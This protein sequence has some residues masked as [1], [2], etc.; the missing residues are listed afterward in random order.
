MKMKKFGLY[1]I[2]L[3]LLVTN[4]VDSGLSGAQEDLSP[5]IDKL[6]SLEKDI[7]D[8]QRKIN[9]TTINTDSNQNITNPTNAADHEIRILELENQLRKTYGLIDELKFKINTLIQQTK[10]FKIE[11][12]EKISALNEITYNLKDKNVVTFS[13][14]NNL[15]EENNN[16]VSATQPEEIGVIKNNIND[17]TVEVLAKIDPSGEDLIIKKD[18][19]NNTNNENTISTNE[20]K[21]QE[22]YQRAYNLLSKGEYAAAEVAFH[23]FIEK[24]PQNSLS[25]N[26]YYWLGETLY[27]RQEYQLAAYNFAKGYKAFPK[28]NKAAD[29]LLKLGMSLHALKKNTKACTTLSKLVQDFPE[30]PQRIA[31]RA[32]IYIKKLE[33]VISVDQ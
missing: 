10:E 29:Q 4:L 2:F 18:N 24:F 11:I 25:S 6:N 28:G 5:I 7:R 33:C 23:S 31:K 22:V 9:T 26:A 3:I 15:S 13:N 12:D 32:Q 19:E 1:T 21:P 17:S 27:V 8:V 16:S 20:A 30:L 14:E